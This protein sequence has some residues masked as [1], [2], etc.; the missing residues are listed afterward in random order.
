MLDTI[1]L[2]TIVLEHIASILKKQICDC[3]KTHKA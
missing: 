1:Q 3:E 2:D